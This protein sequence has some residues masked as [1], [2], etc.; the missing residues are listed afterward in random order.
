MSLQ[1]CKIIGDGISYS[2]S[3]EGQCERGNPG[4][5]MS[6]SELMTFA[7][8]PAKWLAGYGK[9]DD[10][11]K[12]T[13]WGSLVDCLMTNPADFQNQFSLR[14]AEYPE[15]DKKGNETG[16]M[17]PWNANST[18]CK[19]W[20]AN[21]KRI[22]ISSETMDEAQK[23]VKT[24]AGTED[25]AELYRVSQ[26]QV[27]VVGQW[28]DRATGLIVPLVGLIDLVPPTSHPAFGKCL[29]DGK[30]GRN[31]NPAGWARVIDDNGYDVQGALYLDLY[32]AATGE[33]R[34]DFIHVIQE[35]TPPYH[36]VTPLPAMS[37]EFLAWGR[38]KYQSALAKYCQCLKTGIWPSYEPAGQVIFG[39]QYI[40]PKEVWNYR[41]TAGMAG[42]MEEYQPQ[43]PPTDEEIKSGIIP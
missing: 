23:A 9:D 19:E 2:R 21:E 22:V 37:T 31:G 28:K 40:D 14:P 35:N 36:V 4:Y 13:D 20:L 29:G 6:R 1:N 24:F 42:K 33:D 32:T 3:R 30:T 38:A 5:V 11:T 10:G 43:H 27:M 41:K 8:N 25:A 39:L 7:E 34:T 15:R 18:W 12:A 16:T 17:K 26:K